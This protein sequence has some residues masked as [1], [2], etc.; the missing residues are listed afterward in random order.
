MDFEI[1]ES[2]HWR[3]EFVHELLGVKKA[4]ED[5]APDMLFCVPGMTTMTSKDL[6]L[7][8]FTLMSEGECIKARQVLRL[9]LGKQ[10]GTEAHN[11]LYGFYVRTV[12]DTIERKFI[13]NQ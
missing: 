7:A 4:I 11:K 1:F 10:E 2:A 5:S 9:S 12:D 8:W 13:L 3:A 6:M